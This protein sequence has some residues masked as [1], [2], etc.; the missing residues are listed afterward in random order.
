[1]VM[2][3]LLYHAPNMVATRKGIEAAAPPCDPGSENA[4]L[5]PCQRVAGDSQSFD[6]RW[7]NA[8]PNLVGPQR[9]GAQ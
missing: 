5:L 8:S 4:T 7:T 3:A 9:D 1:V 6:Y 2:S